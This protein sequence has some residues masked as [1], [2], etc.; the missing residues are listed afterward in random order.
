MGCCESRTVLDTKADID[1]SVHC[2]STF[3][4]PSCRVFFFL[5]SFACPPSHSLPRNES[6]L[7]TQ[8][9]HRESTNEESELR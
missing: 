4:L 8:A 9:A 1:L 5:H 7:G 2:S 3:F 6:K